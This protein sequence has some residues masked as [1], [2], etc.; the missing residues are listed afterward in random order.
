M[1]SASL[2]EGIED[3]QP[4]GWATLL[5]HHLQISSLRLSSFV[6][7]IFL[8][9]ITDDLGL[10]SL[11]AGLLQGVWWLTGGSRC[12]TSFRDMAVALPTRS[13][14]PG[15]PAAGDPVP[16]RAGTSGQLPEPVLCAL[17]RR[18]VPHDR[19]R[20]PADALPAVGGPTSVHVHQRRRTIPAQP[21]AGHRDQ[22]RSDA[23]HGSWKLASGLLH[24]GSISEV[25]R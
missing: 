24:P 20:G 15:L 22:H 12:A 8:P 17:L 11:Q 6:L 7:G 18:T 14:E 2:S 5:L 16:V 25:A 4:R 21:S 10:T 19:P 3:T 9:F 13:H 23:D 1:T